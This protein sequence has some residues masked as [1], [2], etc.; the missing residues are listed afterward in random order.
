[1]EVLLNLV[2]TIISVVTSLGTI[3]AFVSKTKNLSEIAELRAEVKALRKMVREQKE[4]LKET[5]ELCVK[6]SR[7]Q[8]GIKEDVK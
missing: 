3:I 7:R 1:M 6:I 5:K 4:D 8:K 2:P